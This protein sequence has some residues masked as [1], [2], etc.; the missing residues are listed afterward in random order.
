MLSKDFVDDLFENELYPKKKNHKKA[1]IFRNK[2]KI[3]VNKDFFKK[4]H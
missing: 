1:L 2:R 3:I 4:Y